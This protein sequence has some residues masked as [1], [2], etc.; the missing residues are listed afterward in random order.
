MPWG[1]TEEG[2][3]AE[4][5]KWEMPGGAGKGWRS[6]VMS[7]SWDPKPLMRKSKLEV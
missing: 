5:I 2:S 7:A 1:G 3:L 4:R 6:L